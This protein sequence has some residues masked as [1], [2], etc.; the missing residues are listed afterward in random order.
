MTLRSLICGL[1]ALQKMKFCVQMTKNGNF[2]N[3]K[4]TINA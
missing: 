3:V 2:K 4:N 1:S